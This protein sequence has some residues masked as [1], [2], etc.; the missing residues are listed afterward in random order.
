MTKDSFKELVTKVETTEG[1]RKPLA[2]GLCRVD[3]SQ[4]NETKPIQA[5]FVTVNWKENFASYAAMLEATGQMPG[6]DANELIVPLALQQI[7]DAGNIF[8]PYMEESNHIEHRNAEIIKIMNIIYNNEGIPDGTYCFVA[9]YD[10]VDVESLHAAYLK[11]TALSMK[12]VELR[13]INLDGIFGKLPNVA[14]SNGMPYDLEY[15][16]IAEINLKLTNTYPEIS[17][18]DKFPR[19]LQRII[20]DDNTR[21]LDSSKVRFG[22]QLGAGTTIMPGASYVNFNSGTLGKAMVEGRISSSVIVGDGSDIGGGSSILGILSG[23]NNTPI[24]IGKNTLLGANSV[25][26]IS[27]GDGCILDAGCTILAGTKVFMSHYDIADIGKVNTGFAYMVAENGVSK[28]TGFNIKASH[29][30]GMN[31][32]HIRQDSTTGRTIVMRS[33]RTIELNKDLH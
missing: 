8:L 30:S 7:I 20:P 10:D 33:S 25:C 32:L 26:G 18:V 11:L 31:G 21:I 14:W 24:T 27:L 19:Y 1:Y 23:G 17:H 16:R 4:I 5:T 13:S 12:K 28:D 2:W 22:A 3:Y 29:L 9:I 15:L 6:T